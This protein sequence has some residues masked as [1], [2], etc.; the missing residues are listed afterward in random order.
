VPTVRF[1]V[2]L[3]GYFRYGLASVILPD[4]KFDEGLA[5]VVAVGDFDP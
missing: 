1:L 5:G 2:G 4:A 3:R